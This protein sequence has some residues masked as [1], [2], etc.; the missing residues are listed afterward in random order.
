MLLS[1]RE[2]IMLKERRLCI[3]FIEREEE[4]I[5]KEVE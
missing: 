4:E 3:Y 2:K 1:I 5:M